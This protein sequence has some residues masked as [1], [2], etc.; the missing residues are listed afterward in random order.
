[1]NE[2]DS[3][4][5]SSSCYLFHRGS[6]TAEEVRKNKDKWGQ[7]VAAE[8]ARKESMKLVYGERMGDRIDDAGVNS[9]SLPESK[10]IDNMSP[11]I[12]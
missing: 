7:I 3:F 5:W 4:I 9:S 2:E 12:L 8:R 6:Q 1:M 11:D 10:L